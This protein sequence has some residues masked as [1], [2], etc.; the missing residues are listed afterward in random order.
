MKNS[1]MANIFPNLMS[2]T[3]ALLVELLD[4]TIDTIAEGTFR[5]VDKLWQLRLFRVNITRIESRAAPNDDDRDVGGLT[6]APA[7]VHV[8]W[9][10]FILNETHVDL[11]EVDALSFNV[12]EKVVKG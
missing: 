5:K 6:V 12:S 9:A 3:K 4:S 8:E 10:P 2:N 1:K 7:A 11:I